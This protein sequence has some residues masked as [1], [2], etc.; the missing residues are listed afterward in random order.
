M[1][2]I[3]S[4]AV[5][6]SWGR[7]RTD[8]A[9]AGGE[10]ERLQHTW[11]AGCQGFLMRIGG[12][13]TSG[14]WARGVRAARN[15]GES[16]IYRGRCAHCFQ[17]MEPQPKQFGGFGGDFGGGVS[18]GDDS[19]EGS[20]CAGGP[21]RPGMGLQSARRRHRR[22]KGCRGCGSG[23]WPGRVRYPGLGRH[24]RIRGPGSRLWRLRGGFLE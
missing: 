4:K 18:Y 12:E 11:I 14:S 22:P 5:A 3:R 7:V 24:R 17:R 20:P 2:R 21:R 23:R 16:R 8:H 9:A 1:A 6:N 10:V 13:R 19:V 15:F